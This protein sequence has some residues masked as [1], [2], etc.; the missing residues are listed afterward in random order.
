MKT[1]VFLLIASTAMATM[2]RPNY[3]TVFCAVDLSQ[4]PNTPGSIKDIE[5]GMEIFWEHIR[6]ILVATKSKDYMGAKVI[7]VGN[8]EHLVANPNYKPIKY[9]DYYQFQLSKLQNHATKKD[10]FPAD[11]CDMKMLIP[12]SAMH[13]KKFQA[14]VLISCDQSGGTVTMNCELSPF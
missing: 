4:R 1:L 11:S 9:K 13:S 12:K 6:K 14:P 10:Y 7:E 5:V 2:P 3:R 8:S